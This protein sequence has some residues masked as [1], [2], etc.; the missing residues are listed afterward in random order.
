MTV[1]PNP[2]PAQVGG[3]SHSTRAQH[4]GSLPAPGCGPAPAA[5]PGCARLAPAQATRHERPVRVQPGP[6]HHDLRREEHV[7]RGGAT[8]VRRRRVRAAS[9]LS[10]PAPA[11]PT[12]A[13]AAEGGV[14]LFDSA[15]MY[16]VPQREETCVRGARV[17]R[18]RRRESDVAHPS[19]LPCAGPLRGV[20]G[21]LDEGVPLPPALRC[22]HQGG[23]A[24]GDAVAAGRP[25]APGRRQHPGRLPRVPAAPGRGRGGPAAAAL[26]GQVRAA[27]RGDGVRPAAGLRR[28]GAGAGAAAGPGPPGGGGQGAARLAAWLG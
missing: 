16:P 18:A 15:E 12:P 27:V 1:R 5:R 2:A 6:R 20:L 22:G 11:E 26:A 17:E 21:P 10:L 23:R 19:S 14:T 8:A 13:R 25:A 9:R 28:R 4:A 7:R 3:G 24:G